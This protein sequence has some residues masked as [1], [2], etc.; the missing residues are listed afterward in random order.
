MKRP[1]SILWFRI[2][3]AVATFVA[4]A[5][6][7]SLATGWLGIYGRYSAVE[8]VDGVLTFAW[9]DDLGFLQG[10]WFHYGRPRSAFEFRKVSLGLDEMSA[11]IISC[12]AWLLVATGIA[13]SMAIRPRTKRQG[14]DLCV[15][16]GYS[17]TGNTSGVCPECGE[18]I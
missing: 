12:P 9:S 6:G 17:L 14:R 7:M 13:I 2:T 4:V 18:R 11:Y 10:F 16:C 15:N 1:Q 5:W 3:L 8:C